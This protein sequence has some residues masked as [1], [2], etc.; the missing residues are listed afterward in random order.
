MPITTRVINKKLKELHDYQPLNVWTKWQNDLSSD[1][2]GQ[3]WSSICKIRFQ[4]TSVKLQDF[5]WKFIHRA[6]PTNYRMFK[7]K[8][9]DSPLCSFCKQEEETFIH[10][11]WH[12]P[13][14]QGLWAPLLDWCDV[15]MNITETLSMQNCILFGFEKQNFE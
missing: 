11:F 9:V 4:I 12:C 7:M 10:L 6:L 13:R 1:I 15:N 14:I 3:S 2:V 8:M 5:Y